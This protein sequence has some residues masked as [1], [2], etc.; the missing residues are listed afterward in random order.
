MQ[1]RKQVSN[2]NT[3]WK[4]YFVLNLTNIFTLSV[5]PEPHPPNNTFVIDSIIYREGFYNISDPFP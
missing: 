3:N 1:S 5:L 4:R 2:Y